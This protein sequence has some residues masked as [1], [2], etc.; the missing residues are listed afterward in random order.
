MLDDGGK[1]FCRLTYSFLMD[2]V[3]GVSPGLSPLALA[4]YPEEEK[5]GICKNGGGG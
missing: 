5:N 4:L 2:W 3:D 1:I